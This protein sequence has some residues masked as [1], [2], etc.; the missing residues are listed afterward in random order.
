MK[1]GGHGDYHTIVLAPM[2]VQEMHSFTIEAFRLADKY[3][4]PTMV[5]ADGRLCQM[6]EPIVLH[7]GQ[8]PPSPAKK[9][10]LT[11]A[12]NRKPNWIRSLLM[13]E[14]ELEK[15]NYKLQ[16][17]YRL[18]E[19]N[20]I[21]YEETSAN[22]CDLLVV[23]W[24][25]CARIAKEA[26]SEARQKGL[27]IGIFRPITL[28]PFPTKRLALLASRSKGILMVEMN[29]GQMLDDVRLAAGN[30]VPVFF[31][32]YPGGKVPAESEIFQAICKTSR[33]ISKLRFSN[34][35]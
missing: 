29:C 30:A 33:R 22:R 3:R 6:M 34:P 20:E 21:K 23:A 13:K 11:G 8:P 25:T 17:C 19:Q 16:E 2:S 35:K 5:L 10:A 26:V 7:Q 24:G 9:W 18:I 12:R 4:T 1:G 28:W 31:N 32:G 15:H 27:K 14:G